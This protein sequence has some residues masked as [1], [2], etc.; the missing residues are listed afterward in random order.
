MYYPKFWA[1][2][3]KKATGKELAVKPYLQYLPEIQ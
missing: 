3:V 1:V 2:K